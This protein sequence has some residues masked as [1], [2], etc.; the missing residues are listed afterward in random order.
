MWKM[1]RTDEKKLAFLNNMPT[2]N[3][4]D[5]LAIGHQPMKMDRPHTWRDWE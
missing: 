4:K 2:R 5:T 3:F 1:T